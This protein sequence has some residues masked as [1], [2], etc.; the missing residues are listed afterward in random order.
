MHAKNLSKHLA[1]R[2]D[3]E[4]L[5]LPKKRMERHSKKKKV[6]TA[7][8][9]MA[10]TFP[11]MELFFVIQRTRQDVNKTLA[12]LAT[13]FTCGP[14]VMVCLREDNVI[15]HR[16]VMADV[17]PGSSFLHFQTATL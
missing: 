2:L 10:F 7:G 13:R 11:R 1:Q 3:G 6:I 5:S 16:P 17:R 4:I 12:G 8:A 15:I 9:I 14:V